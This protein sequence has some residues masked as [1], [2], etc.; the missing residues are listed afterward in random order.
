[1]DFVLSL[2]LSLLMS[3]AI[4]FKDKNFE[5]VTEGDQRNTTIYDFAAFY[6]EPSIS[7]LIDTVHF[8]YRGEDNDD[9]D[10]NE[11]PPFRWNYLHLT[12]IDPLLRYSIGWQPEEKLLLHSKKVFEDSH[13]VMW[14]MSQ[15]QKGKQNH[16]QQVGIRAK[17]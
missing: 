2:F 1:M 6:E 17:D 15:A 9:E 11:L 12:N 10:G 16:Q 3:S 13:S 14:Q 5:N 8:F 7:L 4:Y